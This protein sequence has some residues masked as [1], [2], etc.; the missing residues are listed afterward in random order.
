LNT[1]LFRNRRQGDIRIVVLGWDE[2]FL[3]EEDVFS[4][5]LVDSLDL[6]LGHFIVE[7]ELE[8]SI[9]LGLDGMHYILY[10]PL[11]AAA[12]GWVHPLFFDFLQFVV[13]SAFGRVEV[14]K[15]SLLEAGDVR[16]LLLE[17][18]GAGRTETLVLF[19]E[20]V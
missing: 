1:G 20:G 17:S 16:G 4:W 11:L 15:G 10:L 5:K 2:D 9:M 3:E 6:L 14:A 18:N 7:G 13:N 12:G 19:Q 8:Q